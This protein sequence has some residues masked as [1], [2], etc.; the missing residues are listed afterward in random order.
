MSDVSIQV[1]RL[2][3]VYTIGAL[4]RRFDTLRDQ[5]SDTVRSLITNRGRR[6]ENLKPFWA[7]K[8]VSFEVRE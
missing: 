5:I 2:S 1:D 3:K 7:L 6:S 4:Q 8:D